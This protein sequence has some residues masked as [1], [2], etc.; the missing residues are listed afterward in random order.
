[1]RTRHAPARREE[2]WATWPTK[3]RVQHAAHVLALSGA[4]STAAAAI[5]HSVHSKEHSA[6]ALARLVGEKDAR[7]IR[8]PRANCR[9]GS[10]GLMRLNLERS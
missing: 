6:A 7:P 8:D 5:V 4:S 1:M 10:R 3:I 2:Q 9:R